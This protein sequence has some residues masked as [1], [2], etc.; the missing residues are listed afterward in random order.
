MSLSLGRVLTIM[1]ATLAIVLVSC[2]S[3]D[4]E[5]VRGPS[6]GSTVSPTARTPGASTSTPVKPEDTA[7]PTSTTAPGGSLRD[8]RD[9]AR[10]GDNT[11]VPAP[12]PT[13]QPEPAVE[14]TG[15]PAPDPPLYT[16]YDLE[17]STGDFWRFR[18]EYTDRSC[19]QGSGCKTKEGD[20][21]FQVTLGESK[22]WEG[23]TVYRVIA[24]GDTGYEDSSTDRTFVPEWDYLGV[25]GHRIVATN[26]TGSSKLVTLFD[27]KTGAWPGSGFFDGRFPEKSLVRAS[28]GQ[29]SGSNE[30]ATWDGVKTGPWHYVNANDSGGECSTFDGRILCPSEEKFDYNE[31]EYYRPGIGPYAYLFS[32]SMSFSG[33]GF[34]SSFQTNE[35]VALI[36]SS[37]MGDDAGDFGKPTPVPP[38]PTPTATPEPIVLGD[39]L[40]GPIDG[41]MA[42]AQAG[43]QIPEYSSGVNIDSGIVDVVFENP[44]VSGKWSHGIAFRQSGE[45]TF[46][47]VFITSDGTWGHFA[48]GG[49]LDSQVVIAL[50]EFDFNTGGGESNSMTLSFGDGGGI[51][52]V[53]DEEVAKLDMGYRGAS[54]PGDVKVM[55]ALFPSDDLS[56]GTTY[57]KGFVVY[58]LP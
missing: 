6:D 46:H 38:T 13:P 32:Y 41:S 14:A 9:P 35:R 22:V 5:P 18:W 21:I 42:L 17:F 51:F 34:A 49:S 55:T 56:G 43:G 7:D 20:G 15:T 53:N 3:N 57:F 26:A 10:S 24:A 45:E 54:Q 40:F 19:A 39:P 29:L 12:T 30:F 52:M 36:A 33:G 37:F 28:S 31:T 4:S 16:G 2:G 11:P 23:V 50:G 25:D 44:N 58:A 47:A 48:R 1:L 27:G 8:R